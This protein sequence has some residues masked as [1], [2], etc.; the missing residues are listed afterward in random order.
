MP[1]AFLC[2]STEDK[3]LVKQIGRA[4]VDTGIEVWIDEA[5]INVGDSLIAK[6]ASGIKNADCII[7]FISSNSTGSPWVQKELEIAMTKEIVK[8]QVTV[9]PVILDDCDIPFFLIDKLYA[10]FR[11]T[12]DRPVELQKLIR[13]I[14]QLESVLKDYS[15][16]GGSDTNTYANDQKGGFIDLI[17]KT[18]RD[19]T[20]GY[21]GY[22][23][24]KTHRIMG[25]LALIPGVTVFMI[26]IIL[27]ISFQYP[28]LVLATALIVDGILFLASGV[29][30]DKAFDKD[31]RLLLEIE[32]IG[33]YVLPL[34]KVWRA[35]KHA[36][37]N[38]VYHL[39]A[40]YLETAAIICAF[41]IGAILLFILMT[42]SYWRPK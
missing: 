28:L 32:K 21:L 35:Q 10:D 42:I 2:H 11:N 9:L 23:A 34:G 16:A 29:S 6:I 14:R 27:G 18:I 15:Q 1:K 39:V 19:P 5:E 24:A 4:L 38:N 8:R 33:G 37:K 3:N 31:K 36:G 17:G 40:L 41:V 22:R 20:R 13:S 7:A 12:A 25:F 26:I 30:F